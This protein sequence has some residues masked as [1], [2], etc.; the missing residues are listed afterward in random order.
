[1][2]GL[3][4]PP[5]TGALLLGAM[6]D[7]DWWWIWAVVALVMISLVVVLVLEA[8]RRGTQGFDSSPVHPGEM[9]APGAA[10][11]AGGVGATEGPDAD[12]RG[13]ARTR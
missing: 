3:V 12:P 5:E 2:T 8:T 11:V 13:S 4:I 1:M 9:P 6:G 7:A 10:P